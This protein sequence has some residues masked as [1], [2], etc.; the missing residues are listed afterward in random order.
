[1]SCNNQ[2]EISMSLSQP[3]RSEY[4]PA[5]LVHPEEVGAHGSL[6][7]VCQLWLSHLVFFIWT[8]I[9]KIEKNVLWSPKQREKT[10]I[11][12]YWSSFKCHRTKILIFCVTLLERVD[13][14]SV[15]N[16]S[17]YCTQANESGGQRHWC[18]FWKNY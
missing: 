12:K 8:N 18:I 10:K 14:I 6:G 15:Y 4:L 1:M 11:L 9:C 3:I 16:S 2:S 7:F 13:S 5:N 17:W